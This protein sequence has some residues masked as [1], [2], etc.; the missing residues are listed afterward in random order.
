MRLF[1]VLALLG[2]C[3]LALVIN[4]FKSQTVASVSADTT[5]CEVGHVD[6][7]TVSITETSSHTGRYDI[8]DCPHLVEVWEILLCIDDWC[9][10]KVMHQFR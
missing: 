2:L 1:T 7:Y 8:V 3:A 9:D 4:P 6:S 10:V 5:V